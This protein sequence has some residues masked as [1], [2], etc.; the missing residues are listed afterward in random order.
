MKVIIAIVAIIAVSTTALFL[1]MGRASADD[2]TV[3]VGD[4]TFSPATV[5][6]N[7]GDTVTW[8]WVGQNPH[9]VTAD[10]GSFDSPQ[11]TSGSFSHTFNTAGTF[12]Y[13]CEVHGQSMS[14]TVVVQAAGQPTAAASPTTVAAASPTPRP[15]TTPAAG[16]GTP[17]TVPST[18]SGGDD[19]GMNMAAI[20]IAA[21]VAA[22]VIGAA[23]LTFARMRA[24]S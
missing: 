8:N 12:E 17:V 24:R 7:V 2:A 20:V 19:D 23:G 22:G 15:A 21:V 11:Q 3:S 6:I 1:N 18:G 13:I 4:N 16:G 10:D 9:T 14:G 5:T